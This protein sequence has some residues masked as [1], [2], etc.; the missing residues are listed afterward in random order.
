MAPGAVEYLPRGAFMVPNMGKWKAEPMRS[1]SSASV[2]VYGVP[3]HL[4]DHHVEMFL[5]QGTRDMVKEEDRERFDKLKVRRLLTRAPANVS[6][7]EQGV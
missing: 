1:P 2:V 4:E 5:K 6:A 7:T 3:T